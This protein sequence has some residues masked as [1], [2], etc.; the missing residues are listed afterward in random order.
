[1]SSKL[2]LISALFPSILFAQTKPT[3]SVA[4]RLAQLNR[5]TKLQR[6]LG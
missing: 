1:M 3:E 4:L 2:I 6:K 5:F